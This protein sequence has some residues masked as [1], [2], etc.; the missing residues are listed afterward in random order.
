M[1]WNDLLPAL[2][3]ITWF[4]LLLSAFLIGMGKAGIK[5][6]GLIVVPDRKSTRLNS[7]HYS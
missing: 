1:N 2:A 7:S 3:P 6:M 5:G 4:W